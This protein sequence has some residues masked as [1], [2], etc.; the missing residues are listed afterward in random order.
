MPTYRVTVSF[1]VHMAFTT[2]EH[3]VHWFYR[4]RFLAF[5]CIEKCLCVPV[6]IT[7]VHRQLEDKDR[8]QRMEEEVKKKLEEERKRQEEE[9]IRKQEEKKR[10]VIKS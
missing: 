5:K 7:C 8:T 1:I 9:E 2:A 3:A 4:Q 6:T 10:K